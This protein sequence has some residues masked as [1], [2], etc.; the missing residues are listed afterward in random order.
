MASIKML[1]LAL[2]SLT[3]ALVSKH[4]SPPNSP[5]S[6]SVLSDQTTNLPQTTATTSNTTTI[7]AANS[8]SFAFNHVGLSIGD[9]DAAVAFYTNIIGFRVAM[10]AQTF[11]RSTSPDSP[12]FN[13]YTDVNIMKVAWLLSGSNAIGLEL[14]QFVDPPPPCAPA[15]VA[16]GGFPKDNFFHMGITTDEATALSQRI[17]DA[18][19]RVVGEPI[20]SG[21]EFPIYYTMDPWGNLIELLP[22]SYEDTFVAAS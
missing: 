19:G 3:S 7:S 16:N 5:Y 12:I 15:P 18:G 11:N 21:S 17:V 14:F 20:P 2:I 13:I 9:I 22:F 6:T 1:L 10:G 4:C 8:A